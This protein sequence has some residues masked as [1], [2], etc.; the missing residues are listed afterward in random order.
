MSSVGWMKA[1]QITQIDAALKDYDVVYAAAG[2]PYAAYPTSY[3][4]LL[5]CTG[6]QPMVVGA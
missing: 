4:E 3:A 2:H 6:A 5:E 1:H